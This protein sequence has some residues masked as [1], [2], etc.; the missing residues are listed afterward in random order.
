MRREGFPEDVASMV[1]FLVSEE[2]K[3]ITGANFMITG[4]LDLFVI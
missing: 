4:G 1:A 3:Y 2:A